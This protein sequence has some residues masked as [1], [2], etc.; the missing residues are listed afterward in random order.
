MDDRDEMGETNVHILQL[1][2]DEEARCD[3]VTAFSSS[4]LMRDGA[5]LLVATAEHGRLFD[6]RLRGLGYGVDGL[7]ARGQLRVVDANEVLASFMT[8]TVPDATRFLDSV[9]GVVRAM[10]AHYPRV[11]VYEEMADVLWACGN[12]YGALELESLWNDLMAAHKFTLLCG[13]AKERFASPEDRVYLREL[14]VLHE[15][16][17]L[18]PEDSTVRAGDYR[19]GR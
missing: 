16:I 19:F 5:V 2:D 8:S 4:L 18:A 6:E 14:C 15:R 12:R 1:F 9:G 7:K 10:E 17:A 3:A 11:G 13:Y